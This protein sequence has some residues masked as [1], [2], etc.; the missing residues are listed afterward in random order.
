MRQ[1]GSGYRLSGQKIF[2][3]YGEH[4]LAENIIHL[5][6][7]RTPDA[8]AGESGISLFIVPKYLINEDGSRGKSATIILRL[9][10]WSTS[11]A[12]TANRPTVLLCGEQGA[13]VGGDAVGVSGG[14]AAAS[15]MF[16]MM[17]AARY[18]FG[19]QGIGVSG[20][21]Y[22]ACAGLRERN[23]GGAIEDRPRR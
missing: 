23:C 5:V 1:D 6:L 22:L 2:I 10:R 20:V 17:N 3:T 16:I 8:P 11:W 7:A 21:P 12:S 4:G 15:D 18:S 9:P 14:Q 19:Q 13:G